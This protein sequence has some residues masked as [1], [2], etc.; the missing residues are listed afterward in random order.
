M[1]PKPKPKP[2]PEPEPDKRVSTGLAGLVLSPLPASTLLDRELARKRRLKERGNV[3]TRCKDLDEY[4]LLGGLERGCV[5]G[6]SAEEEDTGLLIGM[7]TV[8]SLL[9]KVDNGS[10]PKVLIVTTLPTSV[11]LQRLREVLVSQIVEREGGLRNVQGEVRRCFERIEIARVFDFEGLWEVLR[12]LDA[13]VGEDVEGG[14]EADGEGQ[15]TAMSPVEVEEPELPTLPSLR[16]E[17]GNVKSET[18]A[19]AAPSSSPS[20]SLPPT[21]SPPPPS[22]SPLSPPPLSPPLEPDSPSEQDVEEPE[23]LQLEAIAEPERLLTPEPRLRPEKDEGP[24]QVAP[25]AEEQKQ[26]PPLDE[27]P[28]SQS[29]DLILVTHVSTLLNTLFTGRDMSTAKERVRQMSSQLHQLSHSSVHGNPLFMLLNSTTVPYQAENTTGGN[30]STRP[31]PPD[32]VEQYG[33]R[34]NPTLWSMFSTGSARGGGCGEAQPQ[35]PAYGEFFTQLLDLHLLATHVP[36]SKVAGREKGCVWVVEVL[37]DEL[38]VY[39]FGEDDV[40]T[41]RCREQRWTAVEVEHGSGKKLVDAYR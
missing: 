32:P 39:E 18:V 41:R 29:P 6:V 35:K 26:K 5:V 25:D 22:S 24:A 27:P 30:I 16:P 3:L 8:A 11:L 4:V 28:P 38:G 33:G 17:G 12:E 19:S 15:E 9:A 2:K 21:P 1:E 23:E 36:N 13:A 34:P 14:D 20:S 31:P 40:V 37:L 10:S 7:Q